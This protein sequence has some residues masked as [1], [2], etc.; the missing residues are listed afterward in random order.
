M[1]QQVKAAHILVSSESKARELLEKANAGSD[2][3]ELARKHSDC[4]S[5]KKCGDLG[6]FGCGQMVREFE[7]AAFQG[8]KGSIV[9]P[10]KTQFGWH[11]IKI[12]DQ[13]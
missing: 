1:A 9:G 10:V 8:K 12:V 4:P 5:G 3:G 7:D 6:W 11:L 2:F 13:R